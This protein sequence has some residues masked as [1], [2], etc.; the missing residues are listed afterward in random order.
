M[1]SGRRKNLS[2][3]NAVPGS[4]GVNSSLTAKGSAKKLTATHFIDDGIRWQPKSHSH[5]DTGFVFPGTSNAPP[6]QNTGPIRSCTVVGSKRNSVA[7]L[8]RGPRTRYVTVLLGY[9]R[10]RSSAMLAPGLL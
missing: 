7:R 5:S 3:G 6:M 4:V 8:V 1:S 10:M 9:D 2:R